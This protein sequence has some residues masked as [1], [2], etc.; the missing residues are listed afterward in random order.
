LSKR[1]RILSYGSNCNP[2]QL[3]SKF[4]DNIIFSIR[5]DCTNVDS[6]YLAKFTL[7]GAIP[8][9][10]IPC[11]GT[12]LKAFILFLTEKQLKIMNKT[13]KEGGSYDLKEIKED[14]K[15]ENEEYL[16]PIYTYIP[17]IPIILDEQNKPIRLRAFQALGSKLKEF[18]QEEILKF[19]FKKTET[20]DLSLETFHE[21]IK[22]NDERIKR[23]QEKLNSIYEDGRAKENQEKFIWK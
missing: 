21:K 19:M 1:I 22:K 3:K 4:K 6:V 2:A 9:G 11:Q 13:E 16:S 8:A 10:I 5:C 20:Q 12:I 23:I 17:K 14:C 7:Y 18:N 15:L